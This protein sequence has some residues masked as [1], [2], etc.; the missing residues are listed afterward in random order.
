MGG[1]EILGIV[2][3]VLTAKLFGLV[4]LGIGFVL[5][6]L[7][8]RVTRGPDG[9]RPW[10][11]ALVMI[12]F[13]VV[14]L[15]VLVAIG[16]QMTPPAAAPAP[17]AVNAPPLVSSTSTA[18]ASTTQAYAPSVEDA[19]VAGGPTLSPYSGPIVDPYKTPSPS[20]P[21]A[22]AEAPV[23]AAPVTRDGSV[24]EATYRA[25]GDRLQ[26]AQRQVPRHASTGV[27]AERYKAANDAFQRCI[28]GG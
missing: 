20:S 23:A 19:V 17:A 12:G 18:P 25:C 4:G 27:A 3:A 16:S 26:A 1:S 9:S 2:V 11:A 21:A 10:R 15:G 7:A 14:S 8:L 5:W 6:L 13:I 28:H 24:D 22:R